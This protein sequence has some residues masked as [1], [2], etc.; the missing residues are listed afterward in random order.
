MTTTPDL[1]NGLYERWGAAFAGARRARKLAGQI[2]LAGEV[3]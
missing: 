3:A 1:V 2:E